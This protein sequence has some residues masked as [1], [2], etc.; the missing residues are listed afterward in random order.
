MTI[1]EIPPTVGQNA[2]LALTRFVPFPKVD[3]KRAEFFES[4][5]EIKMSNAYTQA[6]DRWKQ[7][8]KSRKALIVE[9]KLGGPLALGLGNESPYEVGLT[10]HRVYGTPVIPGSAIKGACLRALATQSKATKELGKALFGEQDNA[11]YALFHDAWLDA[12]S[13]EKPLCRDVI[14]VHHPQYYQEGKVFPTDFDDPNPVAFIAV[15]PG[16]KFYFAVELLVAEDVRP[17]WSDFTEAMLCHTLREIGIGG[18]TNAGYGW[19]DI[20]QKDKGNTTGQATPA[21]AQEETWQN[22]SME[23]KDTRNGWEITFRSEGRSA[24]I[25]Q[26]EWNKLKMNAPSKKGIGSRKATIKVILEGSSY[27]VTEVKLL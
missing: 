2:G 22:C 10:L 6:L 8:M 7:T 13:G 15:K 9:A 26:S 3:S 27:K 11:G 5:T 20:P 16:T 18:K 4:V 21:P 23:W 1:R 17:G 14:T 19:F 12:S 25:T 24:K